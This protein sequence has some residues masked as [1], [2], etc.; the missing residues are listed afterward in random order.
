MHPS[1]PE[2]NKATISSPKR[3]RSAADDEEEEWDMRDVSRTPLH[4]RTELPCSEV[5]DS[6][7]RTKMSNQLQTLNIRSD[8][9][10]SQLSF[11]HRTLHSRVKSP[12]GSE[13]DQSQLLEPENNAGL[14]RLFGPSAPT[15]E[16]PKA[17]MNSS[18]DQH[19]ITSAA[20]LVPLGPS[21]TPSTP[22]LRPTASPRSAPRTISPLTTNGKADG[23]LPSSP[24][25]ISHNVL[26]AAPSC[27][28]PSPAVTSPSCLVWKDDEITGHKASDP[29]DDG[30]GINGIG[31]RP[32]PAMAQARHMKRK[33]QVAGWRS[34]EAREAR[35]SRAERRSGRGTDM[36]TG[37][38]TRNEEQSR[39]VRFLE[40]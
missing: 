37:F 10:V 36:N 11:R 32:T 7:P 28:S 18:P 27:R 31:F 24:T 14:V 6:S 22:E 23:D 8:V 34:R 19:S 38:G 16:I 35:I 13:V 9:Q 25:T 30:Y 15:F 33:R 26:P 29:Q 1:G 4:L 40:G 21:S 17:A 2:K 39:R 12:T 20:D 5:H 3:K